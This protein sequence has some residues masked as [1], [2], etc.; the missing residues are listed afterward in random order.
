MAA[1][2]DL[3]NYLCITASANDEEGMIKCCQEGE[4]SNRRRKDRSPKVALKPRSDILIKQRIEQFVKR[5]GRRPRILV[6]SLGKKG[7]DQENKLLATILAESGFDVDISPP[8]QTPRQA[9]RM[10]VEN[11]VH[12]VCFLSQG[13]SGEKMVTDLAKALQA[14]NSKNIRIVI[15]GAISKAEDDSR[16][17]AGVDL[18]LNSGPVDTVAI[19][20]LLDALE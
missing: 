13:D 19:I 15:G 2:R 11:D 17:S 4:P 8:Q 6:S 1:P 5:Q 10:A 14:E 16:M 12:A 18:I 7:H 9:A 20:R 3:I